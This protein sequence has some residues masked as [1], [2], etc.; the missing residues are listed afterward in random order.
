M[1]V[2][3]S[4]VALHALALWALQ[5]G[6]NKRPVE[7]VIPIS[8]LTKITQPTKPTVTSPTAPSIPKTRNKSNT[9]AEMFADKTIVNQKVAAAKPEP[10]AVEAPAP[11][12]AAVSA[13]I[14]APA[15]TLPETTAG[16]GL[17]T[18]AS[19]SSR[20]ITL[21]SATSS[22]G[23]SAAKPANVHLPSADANYI[24]SRKPKRSIQSE[25]MGEF[26]RVLIYTMIG[27]DGVLLDAKIEKSSGFP[28]LD[29]TA[30]EAV[31]TWRFKPGTVEGMPT[32]LPYIIPIAFEP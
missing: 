8:L 3:V 21:A 19:V 6:M 10:N 2:V 22:S 29:S 12:V 31:R 4:V 16:T 23:V 9:S 11:A 17:A 20:N 14:S 18:S 32:A 15:T 7:V 5:S 24:Y 30:L 28:R 1:I 27:S 26:G 13:A 25:K